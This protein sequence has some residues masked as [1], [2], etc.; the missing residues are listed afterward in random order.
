MPEATEHPRT[1]SARTGTARP[2]PDVHRWT[3]IAAIAVAIL[4]LTEFSVRVVMGTRPEL[5]ESA[6]LAEFMTRASTPTLV[7]IMIDTILMA[8]LIVFL[9]GFRQI[10]T[11][12]RHDLQWVAD[13][14][15]G[16]GLVFVAVT[17]A[18]DAMEAGTAL[19]T[20]QMTPDPSAIRALTEGHILMFGST[21]CVLLALV[22]AASGYVTLASNALPRWTG[23]VAWA[24]AAAN[25]VAVP[26]MFGGTSDAAFASAGGVGVAVFA[27][28]PWLAWVIAVGIVTI[29]GRRSPALSSGRDRAV[30]AAREAR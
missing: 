2:T 16:A 28:F 9:A 23:W 13:L 8:A 14:A 19:D 29:G 17:L 12:A 1:V 15:Y 18:G 30:P 21:G 26:S 27:T 11:H 20:V 10:I 4:L 3:G 5:D 24:V 22:S 6:A 7:I 25:L